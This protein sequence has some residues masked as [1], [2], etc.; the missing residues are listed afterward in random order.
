LLNE[1]PNAFNAPTEI[2]RGNASEH[3]T[4]LRTRE[5]TFVAMPM[6]MAMAMAQ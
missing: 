3:H 5:R 1:D 2:S 6:A 4:F